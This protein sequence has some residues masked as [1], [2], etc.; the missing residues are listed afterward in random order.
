[1]VAGEGGVA[2][3]T[4]FGK[5]GAKLAHPWGGNTTTPYHPYVDVWL[6]R[7]EDV[8][9]DFVGRPICSQ[10]S[11]LLDWTNWN[12]WFCVSSSIVEY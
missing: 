4:H 9:F 3:K 8:S 6:E 2:V 1:M 7:T 12:L 10:V 5:T 11:H